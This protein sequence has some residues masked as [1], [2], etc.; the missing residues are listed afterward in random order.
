VTQTVL[1]LPGDSAWSGSVMK[2]DERVARLAAPFD[3]VFL[4]VTLSGGYIGYYAMNWAWVFVSH[5]HSSGRDATT[6]D[7]R[8]SWVLGDSCSLHDFGC[9][10]AVV[11]V[12]SRLL[13]CQFRRGAGSKR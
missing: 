5:R 2:A 8:I 13:R 1:P 6:L 9:P 12:G 4:A 3:D 11:G 7:Q 10:E